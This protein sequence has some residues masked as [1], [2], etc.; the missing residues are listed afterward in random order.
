MWITERKDTVPPIWNVFFRRDES[1]L[2]AISQDNDGD[3][4]IAANV[5]EGSLFN[6]GSVEYALE[7]ALF[8]IGP[9][10]DVKVSIHCWLV[11]AR[12]FET[13]DYSHIREVIQEVR[14]EPA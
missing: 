10:Y 5:Y 2:G 14:D 1:L 8:V 4:F 6:Y 3:S 11:R 12:S 9:D 13:L 7:D